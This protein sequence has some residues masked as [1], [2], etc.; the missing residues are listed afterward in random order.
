MKGTLIPKFEVT[1]S[2]KLKVV[3]SK[4]V[5][6]A[7]KSDLGSTSKTTRD[8]IVSHKE[9]SKSRA[10]RIHTEQREKIS[11]DGWSSTF[12]RYLGGGTYGRVHE[13][14]LVSDD[15]TVR[16]TQAVKVILDD[17]ERGV[18]ALKELDMMSRIRH[19][20]V[21][22]SNYIAIGQTLKEVNQIDC[23]SGSKTP[24]SSTSRSNVAL[25][26]P[27]AIGDMFEFCRLHPNICFEWKLE[28]FYQAC[29][30]VMLLHQARFL[31]LDIKPENI[32]IVHEC[33]SGAGSPYRAQI[34][35]YGQGVYLPPQSSSVS[36]QKKQM[37]DLYTPPELIEPTVYRYDARS[38]VWSLGLTFIDFLIGQ[39]V[40]FYS[41]ETFKS[42]LIGKFG[43]QRLHRTVQ[44]LI[45]RASRPSKVP[46]STFSMSAPFQA[47]PTIDFSSP[48][49][50]SSTPEHTSDT[51]LI[52]YE[53]Q[54]ELID[55][56]CGMLSPLENRIGMESV[57]HHPLF[58]R[59][60]SSVNRFPS[61]SI[62]YTTINPIV[63]MNTTSDIMEKAKSQML[64]LEYMYV[65]DRLFR[66]CK[67]IESTTV[68]TV[69]LAA[70]LLHRYISS[71]SNRSDYW[72][73]LDESKFDPSGT[74]TLKGKLHCKDRY[75]S[76]WKSHALSIAS[77]MWIAFKLTNPL[78]ITAEE[79]VNLFDSAFDVDTL[80]RFER[81]MI[82]ELGG[83]F[84]W[85]NL[86]TSSGCVHH[87]IKSFDYINNISIYPRIDLQAWKEMNCTIE[88]PCES[89]CESFCESSCER[90]VCEKR[91]TD[92]I[93][94]SHFLKETRYYL[95]HREYDGD[96]V[97]R[98]FD[99]SA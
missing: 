1:A 12:K 84:Y 63:D 99:S 67:R 27:L 65:F 69:F 53:V 75:T 68:E 89:S 36:F 73:N 22:R 49:T 20:Y 29:V 37:T 59:L 82:L 13:V 81:S 85:E 54:D 80:K 44:E 38:D 76:N 40:I 71:S 90:E 23:K 33:Q 83:T 86:Y 28:M 77:V 8:P 17:E 10:N 87:L 52:P 4:L 30:G 34:M 72:S 46:T 74:L 48:V 50:A 93:L 15:Q 7:L 35:D 58:D 61:G 43:P 51:L 3:K 66:A 60:P 88:S 92:A 18:T 14:H 94:F 95:I 39:R 41:A 98:L 57:L 79:L 64:T 26:Y 55:L 56:L 5:E 25:I 78:R 11:L 42:E 91:I 19:P 9:G 21:C 32:L 45:Y 24:I 31:H 6:T 2:P 47:P 16:T 70:D 97:V 62:I 96:Y